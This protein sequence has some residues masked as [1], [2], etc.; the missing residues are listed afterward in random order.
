MREVCDALNGNLNRLADAEVSLDHNSANVAFLEEQI[1]KLQK[2]L[3]GKEGER[4]AIGQSIAEAEETIARY[5]DY[6]LG[7]AFR[8]FPRSSLHSSSLTTS[9]RPCLLPSDSS[10]KR[11]CDWFCRSSLPV[12]LSPSFAPSGA[13]SSVRN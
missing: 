12:A 3:E 1:D 13:L 8:Y 11:L 2:K 9:L 4:R 10:T 7:L 5:R 6:R